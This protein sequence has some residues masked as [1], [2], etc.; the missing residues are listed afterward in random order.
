MES[1]GGVSGSWCVR[2]GKPED[3]RDEAV[4]GVSKIYWSCRGCGQ[5]NS[6]V[7]K[8]EEE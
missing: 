1:R 2:C 6:R 4:I 7:V 5:M 3:L 8:L